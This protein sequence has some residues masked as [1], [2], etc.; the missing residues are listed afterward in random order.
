MYSVI[1]KF[2]DEYYL[3]PMYLFSKTRIN[4]ADEVLDVSNISGWNDRKAL[5][6]YKCVVK[7]NR[8]IFGVRLGAVSS[9]MAFFGGWFSAWCAGK[10]SPRKA[11]ADRSCRWR[12]TPAQ[13]GA[14]S[15]AVAPR[16]WSGLLME[17]TC[18]GLQKCCQTQQ[19]RRKRLKRIVG[20]NSIEHAWKGV[21]W[22]KYYD[23]LFSPQLKE[24]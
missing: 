12:E 16:L 7:T 5:C 21:G 13:P 10:V 1:C 24:F 11:A 19:D 6:K 20:L 3:L 2:V 14:P 22:D 9:K 17:I 23:A 4:N 15:G 18:F 8:K